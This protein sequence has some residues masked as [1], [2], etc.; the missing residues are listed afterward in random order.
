[1]SSSPSSF[2][3]PQRGV[4]YMYSFSQR[5]PFVGVQ[6]ENPKGYKLTFVPIFSRTKRV[7]PLQGLIHWLPECRRNARDNLLLAA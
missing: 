2:P 7:P 6:T 1:V 3:T 5:N 4:F